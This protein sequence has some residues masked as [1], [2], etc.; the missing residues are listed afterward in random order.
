M[1]HWNLICLLATSLLA[2]CIDQGEVTTGRLNFLLS[3]DV[4]YFDQ[5]RHASGKLCTR[6][7]TDAPNI[8]SVRPPMDRC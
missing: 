5:P 8:K 3:Q 6:L 7:A 2:A 4:S 1:R